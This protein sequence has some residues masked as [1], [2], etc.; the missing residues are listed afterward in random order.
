MNPRLE[1][2]LAMIEAAMLLSGEERAAKLIEAFRIGAEEYQEIT[3]RP[4]DWGELGHIP[5]IT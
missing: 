2:I 3:G 4:V 1:A 5:E